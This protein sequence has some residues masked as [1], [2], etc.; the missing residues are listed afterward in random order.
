M[1]EEKQ[2]AE[3]KRIADEKNKKIEANIKKYLGADYMVRVPG[4]N[5]YIGKTEITQNIYKKV[6]GHDQSKYQ[7]YP[8]GSNKPAIF[9]WN[10]AIIIC[11]KLSELVG[12]IPVYIIKKDSRGNIIEVNINPEADGFRLPTEEEWEYAAKGG[13][14]FIYSGSDD[15]DKVGWVFD[16]HGR[17]A[18]DVAKKKANGYGLYDMTGNVWEWCWDSH[19]EKKRGIRGG[20]FLKGRISCEDV[21]ILDTTRD[22]KSYEYHYDVGFRIVRS[23][24]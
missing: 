19:G 7:F 1:A 10:G 15:P 13:Q 17:Y 21:Y 4:K 23:I 16:F 12:L 5:Y 14:N 2:L 9:T 18:H 20:S 8:K 3:E 6:Y 11:N 22:Y 24:K